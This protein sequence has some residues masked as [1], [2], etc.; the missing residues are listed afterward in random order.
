MR[1]R[2]R[3][4]IWGS[5]ISAV[6]CVIVYHGCGEYRRGGRTLHVNIPFLIEPLYFLEQPLKR[7][8]LWSTDQR[9]PYHVVMFALYGA[10]TG[11]LLTF[12]LP[13]R[14]ESG[15]CIGCGYDLR[16]SAKKCPECGLAIPEGRTGN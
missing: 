5:V 2:L 14:V 8:G 11:F 4:I 13:K 10:M 15:I 7:Q 9:A 1:C 12:I 16:A 6:L 3:Y